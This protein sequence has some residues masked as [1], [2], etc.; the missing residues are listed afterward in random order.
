MANNGLYYTEDKGGR[1]II[2]YM[3]SHKV[4]EEL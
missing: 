2:L 1:Y 4:S 3:T